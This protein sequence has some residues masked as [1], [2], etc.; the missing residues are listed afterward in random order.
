MELSTD[1]G[2]ETCTRLPFGTD[3]RYTYVSVGVKMHAYYT[4]SKH[5]YEL[6]VRYSL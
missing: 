5:W 1:L 3:V 2:S 4:I 6:A